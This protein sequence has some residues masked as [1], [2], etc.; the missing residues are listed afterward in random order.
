M[1]TQTRDLAA[2]ATWDDLLKRKAVRCGT[3]ASVVEEITEA[4][5]QYGHVIV[6]PAWQAGLP[7]TARSATAIGT[8]R[9][10]RVVRP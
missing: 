4:Q 7:A 9:S 8:T 6:S 10:G 5:E 3:A 2:T 1:Y